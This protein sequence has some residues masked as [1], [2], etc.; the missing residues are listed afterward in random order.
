MHLFRAVLL[1][2]VGRHVAIQYRIPLTLRDH[3]IESIAAKHLPALAG[4]NYKSNIIKKQISPKK[5]IIQVAACQAGTLA[6]F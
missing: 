5:L 2:D 3:P 1:A 4:T 6:D